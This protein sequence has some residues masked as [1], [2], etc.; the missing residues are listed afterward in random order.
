MWPTRLQSSYRETLSPLCRA[1]LLETL[2]FVGN[3]VF[4]SSAAWIDSAVVGTPAGS[5]LVI[6]ASTTC[7]DVAYGVGD[8][9]GDSKPAASEIG[10]KSLGALRAPSPLLWIRSAVGDTGVRVTV[11]GDTIVGYSA[12]QADSVDD[13]EED[14]GGDGVDDGEATGSD[15][16]DGSGGVGEDTSASSDQVSS[17]DSGDRECLE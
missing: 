6:D 16:R 14:E 13:E 7:T 1:V 12:T 2:F 17:S 15:G 11:V 3:S 10:S 8:G 4:G 5:D 9:D